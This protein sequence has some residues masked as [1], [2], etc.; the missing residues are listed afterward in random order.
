[1]GDIPELV[2]TP[3][4]PPALMRRPQH[5]ATSQGTGRE[6]SRNPSRSWRLCQNTSSRR[7]TSPEQY[8][9]SLSNGDAPASTHSELQGR[10]AVNSATSSSGAVLQ[11][12]NANRPGTWSVSGMK[13][14]RA[15]AVQIQPNAVAAF[16][17]AAKQP[18]L[19]DA[20]ISAR[21]CS[22]RT[23]PYSPRPVTSATDRLPSTRSTNFE[24]Y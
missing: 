10:R 14:R 8:I 4:L 19:D 20:S 23:P 9:L 3:S 7:P 1:M 5:D 12:R 21:C 13:N 11:V 16:S 15:P 22:K 24:R 2:T 17:K 18:R 6:R